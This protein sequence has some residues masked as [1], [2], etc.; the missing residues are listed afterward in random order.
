MCESGRERGTR[1]APGGAG[2]SP[3]SRVSSGGG[4]LLSHRRVR[5]APLH[6]AAL[7]VLT[8][9]GASLRSAPCLPA[10]WALPRQPRR[11]CPASRHPCPGSSVPLMK[12]RGPGSE[13]EAAPGSPAGRG[14]H[15]WPSALSSPLSGRA[16][17]LSAGPRQKGVWGQRLRG[18]AA[19]TLGPNW[20]VLAGA[21]KGSR[22]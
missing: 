5:L 22:L 8:L 10:R 2:T 7:S 20:G 4:G 17:G 19:R 15:T 9:P 6:T 12:A 1:C 3:E 14:S 18:G 16:A 21:R 11:G 13:E